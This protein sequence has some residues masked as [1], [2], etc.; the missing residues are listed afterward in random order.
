MTGAAWLALAA[1]AATNPVAWVG[2]GRV[3]S[4]ARTAS[5]VAWVGADA[6]DPPTCALIA[7][8]EWKC[9]AD[10]RPAGGLLVFVDDLKITFAALGSDEVSSARWGR[11]L[12]L[13]TP[14]GTKA[15][16]QV[17]AWR[18]DRSAVRTA[19][20][21]FLPIDER[22]VGI[23]RLAQDTFWVALDAAD[24]NAFIQIEGE[25]VATARVPVASLEGGDVV[26]PVFLALSP[27]QALR[28]T[29]RSGRSTLVDGADVYLFAPLDSPSPHP[30][31]GDGSADGTWIRVAVTQT[32]SSGAFEF[33]ALESGAFEVEARHPVLGRGRTRVSAISEPA[34]VTL[35]D[36]GRASGRVLRAG[37]PVAGVQVRVVPDLAAWQQSADA[38]ATLTANT[39]SDAAGRFVLPLPSARRGVI[40][41]VAPDGA[42]IRIPLVASSGD[43]DV[44]DVVLPTP[45]LVTVRVLDPVG[46]C[47]LLAAGPLGGLGL[48][49]A[50]AASPVN[51]FDL[52]L[53]EPGEW[54]LTLQCGGREIALSPPVVH[55][56]PDAPAAVIDVRVIR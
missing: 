54:A 17:T 25:A 56:L 23:T 40:Q 36:A 37:E 27:R 9:T 55:V 14:D 12:R 47:T 33:D 3:P 28:G 6:G 26:Q 39:Y 10:E 45:T 13:S 35:I 22:G 42:S 29:V 31:S 49:V 43:V 7:A 32:D 30:Q 5:R 52:M 18:P 2:S 21:H 24:R 1:V 16:L 46:A 48:S 15:S 19:T 41:M 51:I 34:V 11:L 20:H 44:G 50:R 8:L 4:I 38:A 53:P